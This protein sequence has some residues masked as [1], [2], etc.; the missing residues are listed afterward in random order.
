MRLLWN[1]NKLLPSRKQP[2]TE[3]YSEPAVSNPHSE[4][5]F[6]TLSTYDNLLYSRA[7]QMVSFLL[8]IRSKFTDVIFPHAAY[9]YNQNKHYNIDQKDEGT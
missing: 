2:V 6:Q 9:I 7:F 5:I 1:L 4:T 8:Y 3:P